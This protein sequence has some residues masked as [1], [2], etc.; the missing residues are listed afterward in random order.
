MGHAARESRKTPQMLILQN[1]SQYNPEVNP[2]KVILN[3]A[4]PEL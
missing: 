2:A 1:P 3:V 4:V